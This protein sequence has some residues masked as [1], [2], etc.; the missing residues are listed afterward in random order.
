MAAEAPKIISTLSNLGLID[1]NEM[2]LN[3]FKGLDTKD[4]LKAIFNP[5]YKQAVK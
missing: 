5:S 3:D 1:S 4:S 2:N